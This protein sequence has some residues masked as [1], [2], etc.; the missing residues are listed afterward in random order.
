MSRLAKKSIKIPEGVKVVYGD[1]RLQVNG[2]KGD[3]SLT[4]PPV[5][6]LDI[7]AS[8]IFVKSMIPLKK[9]NFSLIG[10]F[11]SLI[12]N[13]IIGVTN[14]FE[15]KLEIEGIGYKAE[16]KGDSLVLNL[17]FS[18]P[19][20]V[21][22]PAELKVLVDAQRKISISGID[23]QKVGE[24]TAQIR[25]LKPPEPYKGKGIKYSGEIIRKKAGKKAVSA[26]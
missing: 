16:L 8:E 18:H 25:K 10:T 13:M 1:Y 21:K 19:V 24:F 23:K 9:K 17:G 20:T 15:K 26:A 4:V 2:P 12:N 5:L 11:W 14:G 7:G 3:L 6:S 22:V